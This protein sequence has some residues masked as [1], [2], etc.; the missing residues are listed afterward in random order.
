MER[1]REKVK[2]GIRI[3]IAA[4]A[5]LLA[6]QILGFSRVIRPAAADSRWADMWNGFITGA[7]FGIMALFIAGIISAARALKDEKRLK[8]LYINEHDERVQQIAVAARSAGAQLFMASGLAAGI[9]AGYFSVAVSIAIIACVTASAL[10][11]AGFKVY[12]ARKF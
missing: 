4:V 7:S 3:N 12:Y 1:Y 9:V 6:V 11:C 10:M 5:V 8:K 2:L